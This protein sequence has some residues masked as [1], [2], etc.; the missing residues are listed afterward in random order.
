[1]SVDRARGAIIGL[2]IGDAMG[3]PTEGMTP[4][5]IRSTFGWVTE[6]AADAAGTDDTEYA[7]L[8]ARGV[9]LHGSDLSADAVAQIWL[10]TTAQ[11][12]AGFYGAGF[13]E[14]TAIT[15]LRAGILPPLSGVMNYEL[16]SDGAAMRVAPL[17][18]FAAGDPIEA[19]RLAAIDASVSHSLDG[20]FAAQGIAASV[21]VAMVTDDYREVIQAGLAALPED[22]WTFR[23]VERALRIAKDGTNLSTTM[24]RLYEEISLFHYPWPDSAP[25]AVALAYGLFEASRGRFDDVVQAGVNIGRDSD[26]IAAMAGSMAGAM[27]GY[28]RLPERW[29]SPV[30]TVYG[31][32]ISDTAGT[33]LLD[34]AD[35]IYAAHLESSKEPSNAQ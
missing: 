7:V 28:E 21:S 20:I 32:C 25:E 9:L 12:A 26:T 3:A 19:S 29:K 31:R 22:S 16:W 5:T 14:M 34:L 15:N 6:L 2:A 18:V 1:M 17:G 8:C 30:R 24:N 27:T 23:L 11:Q 4:E 13:S 33:D 35:Q 10:D